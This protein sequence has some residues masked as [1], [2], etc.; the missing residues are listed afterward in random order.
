MENV[1][2]LAHKLARAI[3]DSQEYKNFL[4]HKEKLEENEKNKKMVE[5][6][7][8]KALKLQFAHMNNEEVNQEEMRQL[9]RLEEVLNLNPVIKK[10][11]EAEVRL[12]QMLQD[13]N[14]IIGQVVKIE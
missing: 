4:Q 3:K 5:D 9:K 13:I 7:Q 12:T 1:Y 8:E 6:F 11:L 2:E 10:Y 14:N